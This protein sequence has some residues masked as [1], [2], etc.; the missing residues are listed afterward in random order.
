MYFVVFRIG[1]M[2]SF[3]NIWQKT[4]KKR[5]VYLKIERCVGTDDVVPALMLYAGIIM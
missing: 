5:R 2:D 4:E 3:V 1:K